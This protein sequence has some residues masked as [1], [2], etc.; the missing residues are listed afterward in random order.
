MP[1]ARIQTFFDR[2]TFTASHV[3][4]CENTRRAAVI[5]SVL[6]FDAKS[7]RTSGRSAQAIID[8]VRDACLTVDWHLETHAHAD[9]FSAAAHLQPRLG[10]RIAIG[11]RIREVQTVFKQVFNAKDMNTDGTPF[12]HL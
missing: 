4:W 11:A 12:D 1:A 8:F 9:H 7:G 10:G 5:D 3:V 6:D 2:A